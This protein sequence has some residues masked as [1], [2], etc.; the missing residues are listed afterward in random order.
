VRIFQG[1]PTQKTID[2]KVFTGSKG[3]TPKFEPLTQNGI[4]E[5]RISQTS[6]FSIFNIPPRC[7]KTLIDVYLPA[8]PSTIQVR[9]LDLIMSNNGFKY[10]SIITLI[11]EDG[12]IVLN[13]IS[14]QNIILKTRDGNIRLNNTSVDSLSITAKD[15]NIGGITS[16]TNEL[17]VSTVDGNVRL[18][19][20]TQDANNAQ[21][22]I[23]TDDGNVELLFVSKK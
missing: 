15:G 5:L 11:T 16:L 7:M 12:D 8:T 23:D 21:I 19:L 18:L 13:D 9:D 3:V 17:S 14:A 6:G 22:N 1:Q 4:N 10:Q 2:I 20:G